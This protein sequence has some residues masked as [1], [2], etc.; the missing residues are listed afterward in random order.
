MNK[1]DTQS[2]TQPDGGTSST[3]TLILSRSILRRTHEYFFPYWKAGVETACYWFG[4]E[5][6]DLQIVTTVAVPRLFQTSGNYRVEPGSWRRLARSMKEQGLTNLAQ[7]H[8]HP[9]DYT[10]AHSPFDDRQAYSTQEG[11]LSLVFADYGVA[12]RYDL[13]S[14]GVHERSAAGWTLLEA[15]DVARRIRIVDDFA[16]FRWE[17]SRGEI[18]HYE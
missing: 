10:V 2:I 18:G 5:A 17:I 11:A 7:V 4:Y 9:I 14:I 8:T 13:G 3:L 16:D 6:G 15:K 1:I 12:D